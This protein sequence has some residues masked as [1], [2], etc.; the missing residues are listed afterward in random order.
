MNRIKNGKH[1]QQKSH[2]EKKG[3]I[4]GKLGWMVSG[5]V[6]A[7]LLAVLALGAWIVQGRLGGSSY[8]PEVTGG[9]SAVID[10]TEFD[11]GDVHFNTTV[12][13]VFNV[14]NVGDRDLT[15][16]GEPQVEVVEGC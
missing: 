15:F 10:Q 4:A 5:A 1:K 6:A 9:P 13:T 7:V 8:T 16:Q 3:V 14:K 11:Y 12:E 2:V